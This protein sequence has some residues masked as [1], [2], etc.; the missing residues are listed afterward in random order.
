MESASDTSVTL[1]A[2]NE[3]DLSCEV[4]MPVDTSVAFANRDS[5]FESHH[6]IK[7]I[8]ISLAFPMLSEVS[9]HPLHL[10]RQTLPRHRQ[11]DDGCL[12]QL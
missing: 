6:H 5:R 11:A 3:D 1:L 12:L 8:F 7:G 9:H 10:L 2:E 4:V